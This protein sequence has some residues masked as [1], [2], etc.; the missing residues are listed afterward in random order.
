MQQL[1]IYSKDQSMSLILPRTRKVSAGGEVAANEIEMADGSLVSYIKGFRHQ[2]TYEWDWFPADLLAELTEILRQ[3][4]YF[5]VDYPD[6][7]GSDKSGLFKI[8]MSNMGIFKFK[9]NIPMWRGLTLT[10]TAQ[11][12]EVIE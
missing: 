10:L 7:D 6:L 8:A 2:M 3:G 12:V 1:K 9:N 11:R 5:L 4:G